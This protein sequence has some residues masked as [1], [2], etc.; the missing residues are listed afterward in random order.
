MAISNKLTT[1]A[2]G[3]KNIRTALKEIDSNFGAGHIST[4]DD[5][6]RQIGSNSAFVLYKD[7]DGNYKTMHYKFT[8]NVCN[9]FTS[10][11][12]GSIVG[13]IL[14]PYITKIGSNAFRN[15]LDLEFIN[16][17]NITLFDDRSLGNCPKLKTVTLGTFISGRGN[18]NYK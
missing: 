14:P 7:E 16:L 15:C 4:L 12:P 8:S 10:S 13:V 17:E 1:V 5:E 6:I 9:N 3:V 2:S 11:V 18:A